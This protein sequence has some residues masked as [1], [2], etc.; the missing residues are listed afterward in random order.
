L[1]TDTTAPLYGINTP[2][3]DLGSVNM[4][5]APS[6]QHSNNSTFEE[7]QPICELF[8]DSEPVP[9]PVLAEQVPAQQAV[10]QAKEE[11]VQSDDDS[12]SDN[13]PSVTTDNIPWYTEMEY[14]ESN[15][16]GSV[17]PIEWSFKDEMGEDMSE[18]DDVGSE[19]SV[20]DYFLACFSPNAMKH[21]L[22]LTNKKLEEDEQPE[23]GMGELLKFFGVLILI[24][25]FEFSNHRTCGVPIRTTGSFHLRPLGCPLECQNIGLIFYLQT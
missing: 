11:Q 3:Q 12:A 25:R 5:E 24:T 17:N 19:W 7:S 22:Y 1:C 10:E 4:L 20:L 2:D 15:I 14:C 6:I 8:P 16:N 18:D 23:M 21:I 9:A 13:N